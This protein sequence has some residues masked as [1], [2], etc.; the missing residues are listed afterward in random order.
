MLET[1]LRTVFSGRNSGRAMSALPSQRQEGG[2]PGA[3]AV[4]RR[5]VAGAAELGGAVA[6][7]L[8]AE[9]G[10]R[11]VRAAAAVVDDVDGDAVLSPA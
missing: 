1:W 3:A 11:V 6:H 8:Q 7:R 5:D 9:P 4:L 10:R 2:H